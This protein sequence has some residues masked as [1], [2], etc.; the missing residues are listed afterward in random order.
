MPGGISIRLPALAG[1]QLHFTGESMKI[2][3]S[4]AGE[5]R[6]E[7]PE[8][9]RG[10]CRLLMH[11]LFTNAVNHSNSSEVEFTFTLDGNNILIEMVTQG[12]GFRIK[13]VNSDS[14]PGNKVFEPPFS[15]L[16]N[17]SFILHL[18]SD[19]EV[20]CRVESENSLSLYSRMREIPDVNKNS[21]IPEHFGLFIITR[22]GTGVSYRKE[23]DGRNI[24]SLKRPLPEN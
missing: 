5:K 23:S 15:G 18:D 11:E 9:Y 3:D 24:F 17:R 19:F 22:L 2:I 21:S 20:V 1:E 14:T 12:P 7:L 8:K 13:P 6:L 16:I 10:E 4:L